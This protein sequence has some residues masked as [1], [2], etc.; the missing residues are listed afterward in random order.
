MRKQENIAYISNSSDKTKAVWKVINR[1]TGKKEK[2]H[3][4]ESFL[5]A[6]ELNY[7][8][9]N[10]GESVAPLVKTSHEEATK[11]LRKKTVKSSTIQQQKIFSMKVHRET[12]NEAYSNC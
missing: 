5:T 11:C 6:D 3:N 8:F 7:F 10:I 12:K 9:A 2:D 4:R 1:E